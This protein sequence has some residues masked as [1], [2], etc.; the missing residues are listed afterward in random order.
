MTEKLCRGLIADLNEIIARVQQST[1]YR[2]P[3]FCTSKFPNR[4][5]GTLLCNQTGAPG[6]DEMQSIMI[7]SRQESTEYVQIVYAVSTLSYKVV[8][9]VLVVEY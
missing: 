7:V 9:V 4:D 3:W 6:R 1:E 5:I 2:Y 8:V